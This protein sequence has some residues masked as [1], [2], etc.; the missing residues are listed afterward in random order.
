VVAAVVRVVSLGLGD[1]WSGAAG[2]A[3]VALF[4]VG[5]TEVREARQRGRARRGYARVLDGE[6][7][8]NGR[9]LEGIFDRPDIS[10]IDLPRSW[11]ER[12]PSDEAWKEIR[13]PLATLIKGEDFDTLDEHY[14]LLGVLLDLKEHPEEAEGQDISVWGV[15]SD[16][17]DEVPRLRSMLS[18][19]TK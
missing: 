14:R 9:A 12:P 15:S 7:E 11:L 8:A 13:V 16:L 4:T 6:I 19:Y 2:A 3:L 17:K 5:Y 18:K 10:W 1:L